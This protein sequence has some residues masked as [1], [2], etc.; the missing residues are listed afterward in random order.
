MIVRSFDNIAGLDLKK[1][2]VVII[3]RENDY[4]YVH[5]YELD[6]HTDVQQDNADHRY[7]YLYHNGKKTSIRTKISHGSKYKVYGDE[8]LVQVKYQLRLDTKGQLI[9]FC[10]CPLSQAE[11]INLLYKKNIL[12]SSP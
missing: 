2:V 12:K 7:F 11:Y 4:F 3:E 6:I 8:L 1:P 9:D 10:N 5:N